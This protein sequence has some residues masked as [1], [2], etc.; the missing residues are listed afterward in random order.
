[1]TVTKL[2]EEAVT[3]ISTM[4]KI[5]Q[6]M[7]SQ[8]LVLTQVSAKDARATEVIITEKGRNVLEQVRGK[9][10]MVGINAFDGLH[11]DDLRHLNTA[12]AKMYDNL[13]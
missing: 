3:K 4:A 11:E 12:A 5:I 6:R 9:V 2:S 10:R 1:V 8:S 7:T 13:S